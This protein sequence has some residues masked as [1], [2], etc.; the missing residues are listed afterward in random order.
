MSK[1]K[2]HD[3][4]KEFLGQIKF[5]FLA[6]DEACKEFGER[7]FVPVPVSDSYWIRGDGVDN[8][9]SLSYSEKFE[10]PITGEQQGLQAL[11]NIAS[12]TNQEF[13]V[14]TIEQYNELKDKEDK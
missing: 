4:S 3:P 5:G 13:I 2:S 9:Y 14:L 6:T 8:M 7:N 1:N 10:S 11:V 12:P